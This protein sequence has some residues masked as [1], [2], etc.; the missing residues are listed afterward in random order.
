MGA[1]GSGVA[2]AGAAATPVGNVVWQGCGFAT[3]VFLVNLGFSTERWCSSA[4]EK[5]SGKT[6]KTWKIGE[7]GEILETG[8]LGKLEKLGKLGKLGNW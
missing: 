7:T 5:F 4:G 2:G 8:E 6:G 3:P 1:G